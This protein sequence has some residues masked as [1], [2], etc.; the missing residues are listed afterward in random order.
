MKRTHGTLISIRYMYEQNSYRSYVNIQSSLIVK[1]EASARQS[2]I[3]GRSTIENPTYINQT[4]I[5]DVP[6]A[7]INCAPLLKN[8]PLPEA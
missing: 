6:G 7:L 4:F 8:I 3:N 5:K 1:I 2:D